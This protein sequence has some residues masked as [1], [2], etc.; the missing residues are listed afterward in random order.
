MTPILVDAPAESVVPADSSPPSTGV[1]DSAATDTE[2]PDGA[3]P[4]VRT[5]EH[6]F[7]ST[8]NPADPQRIVALSEEFLLAD[9][10]ALGIVPI[11]STSNDTSVFSGVDPSVTDGIENIASADFNIEQLAALRPDLTAAVFGLEQQA[12]TRIDEIAVELDAARRVLGG[13]RVSAVSISPGPFI[14]A[15]TDDRTVLT[16][17]MD[18]IDMDFVP[19]SGDTDDNGRIEIS[20]ERL[21]E[22]SGDLLLLLQTTV[23]EGEDAA[24]EQ[25]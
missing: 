14:R 10:L 24:V 13:T 16:E 2:P 25:R 6:Q 23:I 22:L 8:E 11:A 20:L 19:D 21:G 15:Y 18:D 5:I 9:L 1:A 17:V 12:A 7:A 4:G 3:A